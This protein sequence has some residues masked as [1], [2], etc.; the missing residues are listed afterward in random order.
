MRA[1]TVV[2]V[3][4]LA[5]AQGALAQD[6]DSVLE[7]FRIQADV[8][9]R[10]L[11]TDLASLDRVQAQ[12]RT[13]TDRLMR[14]GD[15]LL[16]AQRDGE[17]IGSLNARSADLRHAE[18][19]VEDLIA[20]ARQLRGNIVARRGYLDQVQVEIK[21]LEEAAS[22]VSDEL[23]GRWA[24]AIEPG[25]LKG[26]FDVRLDG[27]IVTGVYQLSGGWKGSLRG[28]FV[29]GN[30]HL[31]RIDTQQG[32]VATYDGRLVVRGGEKRLEGAWQ[33]TNLAAGLPTSGY[34]VGRRESK[35]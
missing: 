29:D 9:K 6:R 14:L 17:D 3:A 21:R 26:S 20:A 24:V 4:A 23:T 34:W 22:P 18:S 16:R 28:T 27:T 32:F 5:V 11:T 33:A 31:E 35:Q 2:V 7:V 13:A 30:V 8:E 19:E 12:M 25:G 15:D 1:C 10:L